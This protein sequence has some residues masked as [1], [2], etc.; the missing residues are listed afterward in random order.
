MT[1][2]WRK[3]LDSWTKVNTADGP[4]WAY[5]PGGASAL[6]KI[7]PRY[8]RE[9]PEERI[10]RKERSTGQRDLIYEIAYDTANG[11]KG[12]VPKVVLARSIRGLLP[13]GQELVALVAYPSE[14][15]ALGCVVAHAN[16]LASKSAQKGRYFPQYNPPKP[17]GTPVRVK[18]GRTL[19]A[20]AT[21]ANYAAAAAEQ[22]TWHKPTPREKFIEQERARRKKHRQE[23]RK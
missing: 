11:R 13:S 15:E 21:A 10:L 20:P 14:G 4:V 22:P 7:D 3:S 18:S 6:G 23:R 9:S 2:D 16:A 17:R 8:G 5:A 12:Y 19:P 1:T